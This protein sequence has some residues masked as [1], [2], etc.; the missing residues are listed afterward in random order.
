MTLVFFL[1][2][3]LLWSPDENKALEAMEGV[4]SFGQRAQVL[5][6]QRLHTMLGIDSNVT[7]S[8]HHVVITGARAI[9]S[10]SHS[11]NTRRRMYGWCEQ[12]GGAS[13]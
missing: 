10:P 1:S 5:F 4:V 11:A 7:T 3:D 6:Q 12:L 9:P 8:K 2:V 13:T